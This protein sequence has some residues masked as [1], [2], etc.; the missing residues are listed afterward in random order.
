MER[1]ESTGRTVNEAIEHALVRLQTTRDHVDVEVLHEGSRGILGIGAEDA[2]VIVS[3][4]ETAS[5]AT[6]APA[7]V[8]EAPDSTPAATRPRPAARM[9]AGTAPAPRRSDG[10]LADDV[11]EVRSPE[12]DEDSNAEM[13]AVASD[14]LVDTSVDTVKHL[15]DLLHLP[16]EV[17]VRSRSY[18]LTLNIRGQGMGILIGR[19]GDTL[20]YVQF[21][22]NHLVSRQIGRWTRVVV[23]V[24]DY[25]LRREQ[26]VRDIASR[27][28][29]RVRRTRQAIT[30]EPMPANERRIV[31]LTLQGD[32]FVATHSVGEGDARKVVI[33]PRGR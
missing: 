32:R 31:H 29:E 24:E 25:R 1:V 18:P 33:T 30:L 16:A 10:A 4:I 22:V 26:T 6:V 20:G 27:V 7:A 19:H 14:E 5:A 17:D 8:A 3:L 11:A 2:R 21:M 28:A 12:Y 9:P 13:E 15:L 23:D